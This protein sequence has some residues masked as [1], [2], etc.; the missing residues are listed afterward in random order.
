MFVKRFLFRNK[1]DKYISVSKYDAT[2]LN[3][4]KKHNDLFDKMSPKVPINYY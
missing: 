3:K 4:P 1:Q 2:W